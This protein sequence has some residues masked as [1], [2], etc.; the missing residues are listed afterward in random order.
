MIDKVD[1]GALLNAACTLLGVMLG[2]YLERSNRAAVEH[3]ELAH[4]LRE[5]LPRVNTKAP[6]DRP[7]KE[8]L[9]R[10][11]ETASLWDRRRITKAVHAYQKASSYTFQEQESGTTLYADPPAVEA[12]RVALL[13]ALS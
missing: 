12:A 5:L 4:S 9:L 7:T 10:L 11:R 2:A 13:A 3:R 6:A 1:G 8:E